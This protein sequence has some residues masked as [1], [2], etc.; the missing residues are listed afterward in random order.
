MGSMLEIWSI[1]ARAL[2]LVWSQADLLPGLLRTPGVDVRLLRRHES[3]T[4]GH[5]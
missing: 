2:I 4:I 3:L 5:A 1:L